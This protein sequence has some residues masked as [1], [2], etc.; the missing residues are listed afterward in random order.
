MSL[1]DPAVAKTIVREGGA[2]FT[3][4][5][6][7]PGGPTKYGIAQ[8]Y[9]PGVDVKNLTEVGAKAI[10]KKDYWDPISGD[11]IKDQSLAEMLFDAAVNLGV[12]R[13]VRL[14]Q[15][16]LKMIPT[17]SMD[18]GT[19]ALLNA[20]PA[21]EAGALFTLAKIAQYVHLC[22]ATPE[23]KKYFYGWV[24]RALDGAAL[25]IFFI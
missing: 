11:S 5:P 24:R 8:N 15:A 6:S 12:G 14:L 17:G 9:H 22:E 21:R 7:D 2:K 16:A 1:F 4:D 23:K 18:P 20:T 3:N 13:T 25:M 10:Y 19:L